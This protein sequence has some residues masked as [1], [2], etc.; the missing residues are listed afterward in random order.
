MEGPW[1]ENGFIDTQEL[2]RYTKKKELRSSD[3]IQ[4]IMDVPGVSLVRHIQMYASQFASKS[5]DAPENQAILWQQASWILPLE[6]DKAPKLIDP[7]QGNNKITL[8]QGSVTVANIDWDKVKDQYD[9]LRKALTP[10]ST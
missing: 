3:L 7:G 10:S 4:E 1:L 6:A 5:Q 2:E 8:I 9:E